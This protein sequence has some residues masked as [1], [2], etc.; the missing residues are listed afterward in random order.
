MLA[1][2]CKFFGS[3]TKMTTLNWRPHTEVP[4][5]ED[6]SEAHLIAGQSGDGGWFL[7]EGLFYFASHKGKPRCW[8]REDD[9]TEYKPEAIF[10]WIPEHELFTTLPKA[11]K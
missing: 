5:P 1:Q 11:K 8:L 6:E 2:P 7:V 3:L 4:D 10:F 9:L